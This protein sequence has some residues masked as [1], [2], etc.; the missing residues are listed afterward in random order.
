MTHA[1]EKDAPCPRCIETWG[2]MPHA[3]GESRHE[4]DAYD[5]H[6]REHVAPADYEVANHPVGPPTSSSPRR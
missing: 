3:W 6:L 4:L 2:Q 1:V 5:E